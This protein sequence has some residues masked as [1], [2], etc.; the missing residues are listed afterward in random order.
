MVPRWVG[1]DNVRHYEFD[2]DLLKLSLKTPEGR[3]TATL[4]W[5]RFINPE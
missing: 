4:T 3:I 2:G 5:R 1:G